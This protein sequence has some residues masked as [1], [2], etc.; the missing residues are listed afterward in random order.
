MMTEHHDGSVGIGSVAQ[1]NRA[2]DYGSEGCRFESCRSHEKRK[3]QFAHSLF[4][5]YISFNV[6]CSFYAAIFLLSLCYLIFNAMSSK[7]I[8]H[9]LLA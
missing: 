3:C 9:L 2:S 6:S 1:L 4:Y 7:K 8:V 5:F